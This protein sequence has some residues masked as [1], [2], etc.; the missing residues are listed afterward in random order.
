MQ[1][2]IAYPITI[3]LMLLIPSLSSA[4]DANYIYDELGRLII[5]IDEQ[6]NEG[7]Y[8]YDDVGNLISITTTSTT[9]PVAIVDINPWE[10]YEGTVVTI[11][12][13]WS[14]GGIEGGTTAGG[15]ITSDGLY[16]TPTNTENLTGIKVTAR[17]VADLTKTA[18][19]QIYFIGDIFSNSVSAYIKE[20]SVVDALTVS[21]PDN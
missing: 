13:I 8:S 5:V 4:D 20:S 18:E 3:F 7:I 11:Y 6:G 19:A 1:K 2:F 14:V 17:S 16:T 9:D 15:T 10:E 21:V 12:G